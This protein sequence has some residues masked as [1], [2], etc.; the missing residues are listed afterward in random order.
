[1]E[2]EDGG[3]REAALAAAAEL[4]AD[5]ACLYSMQRDGGFAAALQALQ[6]RLDALPKEDWPAAEEEAAGVAALAQALQRDVPKPPDAPP[7]AEGAA[8][9]VDDSSTSGAPPAALQLVAV[10]AAE[11]PQQQEREAAAS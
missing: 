6:V 4:A 7:S 9:V 11:P 10:P 2:S 8:A 3:V 1:M 5:D